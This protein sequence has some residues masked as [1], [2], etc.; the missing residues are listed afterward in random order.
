MVLRYLNAVSKFESYPMPRINELLERVGGST[1]I[2]TLD[3][4]RGY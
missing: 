1:F 4:S 3:L 2:T